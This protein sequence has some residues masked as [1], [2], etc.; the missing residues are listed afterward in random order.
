MNVELNK[1]EVHD[2]EKINT[3]L[4][5]N[6]DQ[7]HLNYPFLF[8]NLTETIIPFHIFQKELQNDNSYFMTL[9]VDK[10]FAG[11]ILAFYHENESNESMP[12]NKYATLFNISV[13]SPHRRSGYGTLLVR[14]FEEWALSKGAQYINLMVWNFNEAAKKFYDKFHYIPGDIKMYKALKHATKTAPN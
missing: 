2:F 6:I 7:Y 11:C 1:T 4:L 10:H 13:L 8:S 12:C 9:T 14:S 3:L 5:E